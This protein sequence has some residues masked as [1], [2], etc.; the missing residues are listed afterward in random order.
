METKETPLWL[1]LRKEYIDDNFEKLLPYLK[2][3]SIGTQDDFYAI[4][5]SLLKERVWEMVSEIGAAPVYTVPNRGSNVFPIRLLASYLLVESNSDTAFYVFLALFKL[6]LQTCRQERVKKIMC[7]VSN[8]LK[9]TRCDQLGYSWEDIE[10]YKEEIFLYK[11]TENMSFSQEVTDDCFFFGHGSAAITKNGMFLMAGSEDRARD[12]L[13]SGA[14]SLDTQ[15]GSAVKTPKGEK[16][17]QQDKDDLDKIE[18]FL[19]DF[20]SSSRQIS[21]KEKKRNLLT[22]SNGDEVVARVIKRKDRHYI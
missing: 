16:M 4:T 21:P 8:R 5:I 6:F 19:R 12:I 11:L 2:R 20:V 13:K 3:N 15:I 7:L 17:K 9:H 14:I 1:D 18:R 22:Y 10:D